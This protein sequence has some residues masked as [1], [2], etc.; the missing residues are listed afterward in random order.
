VYSLNVP[1]PGAVSRVAADLHPRLTV[2]E[3][4][5]ER[6]TLLVKRF[7]ESDRSRVQKRLCSALRGAPAFELR[8]AG[9]DYFADPLRGPGPVVYL[10]VEGPGL[11]DLHGRL[12]GTF[13]AV[14]GLEGDDYVPHVTLARGGDEADARRLAARDVPGVTWTVNRVQLWDPE[15][16]EAVATVGLPVGR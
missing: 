1:L 2:F 13:G 3:R 16:R 7:E 8:L 11:Y 10:A 15:H 5:R 9:V 4:I 12:V 6:P 14:P